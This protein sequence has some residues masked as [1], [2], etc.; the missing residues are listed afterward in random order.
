MTRIERVAVCLAAA[1]LPACHAP[2]QRTTNRDPGRDVSL[3]REI[4]NTT[5]RVPAHATLETL[6]RQNDVPAELTAAVVAA[7][8]KV[9]NPRALRAGE[10]YEIRRTVTGL[11]REFRYPIDPDRL[12]RVA[13]APTPAALRR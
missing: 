7:V 13:F 5:A 8:T 3:G 10:T 11:V 6:L 12:L 2:A 1:V 9:F 4:T